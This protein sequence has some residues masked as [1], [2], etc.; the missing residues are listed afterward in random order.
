[1]KLIAVIFCLAL[2]GTTEA[3][4]I[5]INRFDATRGGKPYDTIGVLTPQI[6]LWAFGWNTRQAQDLQIGRLWPVSKTLSI[7][8]YAVTWPTQN[9][10][11]IEP[12]ID[13]NDSLGAAKV[14]ISLAQYVPL[15][16]GPRIFFSNESSIRWQAGHDRE[17]GIVVS[18]WR[19]N[20]GAAPIRLGPTIRW[21]IGTSN[22][23]L[24]WQPLS[25]NGSAP[26]RLRLQ[27][28]TF[29]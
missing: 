26:E 12:W 15:N 25:F 14:S 29:F 6:E 17:A 28:N 8:A 1:M 22:V 18:F 20:S 13:Y 2:C 4:T 16:G 23:R 24:N 3:Q 11:F 9:K 21:K 27:I 7:G 5:L 19:E 10:Q